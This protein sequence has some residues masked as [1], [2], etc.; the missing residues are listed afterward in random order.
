MT[1]RVK[2]LLV[3][4]NPG[5]VDL[6]RDQWQY[7]EIVCDLQVVPDGIDAMAYLRNEGEYAA[8]SRPDLILLDL[9]LPRMDGWEVLAELKDD[10]HLCRIPVAVLTSSEREEDVTRAYDMHA[11]TYVCK[12]ADLVGYGKIMSAIDGFWLSVVRYSLK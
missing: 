10:P 3:E 1:E 11:S 9:N 5:D 4:D 7:S 2:V 6:I 8:A 12:P